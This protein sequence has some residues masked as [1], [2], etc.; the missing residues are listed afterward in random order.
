[1]F[2]VSLCLHPAPECDSNNDV[3][4]RPFARSGVQSSV[5]EMV[6]GNGFL[7]FCFFEASHSI[8]TTNIIC[9]I[10]L[11]RHSCNPVLLFDAEVEK[12]CPDNMMQ[13]KVCLF[14]VLL[15]S[16]KYRIIILYI[17]FR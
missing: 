3:S 9:A 4:I 15:K 7:F 17:V 1:M 5:P 11:Q 12:Y 6:S 14:T 2:L 13:I 8:I 16:Q 10:P